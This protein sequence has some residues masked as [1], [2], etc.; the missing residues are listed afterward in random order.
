MFLSLGNP[1]ERNAAEKTEI[2]KADVHYLQLYTQKE[3]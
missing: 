3:L 1:V 2:N